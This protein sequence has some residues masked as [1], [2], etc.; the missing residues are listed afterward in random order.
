MMRPPLPCC[1]ARSL[2]EAARMNLPAQAIAAFGDKRGIAAHI[3]QSFLYGRATRK[4][5]RQIRLA[6]RESD[7]RRRVSG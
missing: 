4:V 6:S 7:M 1:F 5:D 3:P 2:A